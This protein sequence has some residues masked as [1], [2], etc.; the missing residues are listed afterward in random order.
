M[1]APRFQHGG[2]FPGPLPPPPLVVA[3][4]Q[5]LAQHVVTAWVGEQCSESPAASK[6]AEIY[7]VV[8]A[9]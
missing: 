5:R 4:Y 6:G 7:F 1:G 2:N 3:S 8:A 9:F